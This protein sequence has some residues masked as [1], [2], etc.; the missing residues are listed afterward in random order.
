MAALTRPAQVVVRAA[1]PGEGAAVAALWRELWDAHEAWGGYP[2]SRDPRV[3][4]QLAHRLDDD[5]RVRGGHP[6]LGRHV[7]L[8]SDLD[9]TP[10][11]QVEGWF[12]RQGVESPYT[13]EVRSLIVNER[14]RG[15]GA[16]RA[17]LEA[18]GGAARSLSRDA[19]CILAAEVL[20]PNPAHA[21]YARVGYT[22]VAWC[23]RVE[24]ASGASVGPGRARVAVPQDALAMARLESTLAARRRDAGDTRFDR[25]RAIDATLVGAIAAHLATHTSASLRDPANLVAVD[26]AGVV[27]AAASFTVHALEPPFVPMRR[28]LLGRFSVDPALPAQPFVAPLVAL[29]CRMAL[30]QGAPHVELT[31]LSAPGTDLHGAALSTGARPW[32][33]VVTR[34]A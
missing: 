25:P 17:L 34:M 30:A 21:F 33:R 29:G 1:F 5:V 23:A 16:G 12:D 26:A 7:H 8:V 15:L 9:G 20:E 31:D 11:G 6:I 24:A 3:Y 13:C 19:P 27:R 22:P 4:A 10:C 2:G 14:V 28:A 32:S 18:L